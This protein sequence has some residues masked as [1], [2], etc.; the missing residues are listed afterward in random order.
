MMAL[1]REGETA[2]AEQERINGELR[3]AS[4][5]AENASLE[6]E[7]VRRLT[8]EHK[9]EQDRLEKLED[10]LRLAKQKTANVESE[11]AAAQAQHAD[12]VNSLRNELSALRE[13]IRSPTTRANLSVPLRGGGALTWV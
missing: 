5:A 6:L 3:K 4:T 7:K 9:V 1:E 8:D 11:K 2:A 13:R 10:D 12:A